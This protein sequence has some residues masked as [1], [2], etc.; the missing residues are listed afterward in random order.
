MRDKPRDKLVDRQIDW[1]EWL[2]TKASSGREKGIKALKTKNAYTYKGLQNKKIYILSYLETYWTD[3][4]YL[5]RI[6]WLKR[7]IEKWG[8][9]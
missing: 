6:L 4:I 7:K 9:W 1:N 3:P 5:P 2:I 8:I